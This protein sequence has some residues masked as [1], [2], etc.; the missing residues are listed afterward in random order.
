MQFLSLVSLFVDYSV[1]HKNVKHGI[2]FMSLSHTHTLRLSS[3]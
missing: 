2:H 1:K 3:T